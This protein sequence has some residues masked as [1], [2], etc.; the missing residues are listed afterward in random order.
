MGNFKKILATG[1]LIGASLT[2]FAQQ[3]TNSIGM[4]IFAHKWGLQK[5]MGTVEYFPNKDSMS[6]EMFRPIK[7]LFKYYHGDGVYFEEHVKESVHEFY[8]YSN[9][10]SLKFNN[11][12]SNSVRL[13]K[14]DLE[15]TVFEPDFITAPNALKKIIYN[16]DENI[17]TAKFVL[18]GE[19][20]VVPI[21]KQTEYN[22]EFN[23][24]VIK[25]TATI[26]TIKRESKNELLVDE[27]IEFIGYVKP[28]YEQNNNVNLLTF[29]NVQSPNNNYFKINKPNSVDFITNDFNSNI[30]YKEFVPLKI[31]TT[32]EVFLL[33]KVKVIIK[34][35]KKD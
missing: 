20:Y 5:R 10:D 4:D 1:L 6:V 9:N 25:Y 2:S 15:G 31:S 19:K 18:Y 24:Q 17:D 35:S 29:N 23:R 33:G 12:H 11:F 26:P 3:Y 16:P 13:A 14:S 32:I 34:P 27:S 22:V 30:A 7:D 8:S 21:N 28:V